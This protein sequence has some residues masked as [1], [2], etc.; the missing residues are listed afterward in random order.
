LSDNVSVNEAKTRC[1]ESSRTF[2]HRF[3]WS[4]LD[5]GGGSYAPD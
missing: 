3:P 1:L 2:A 5:R 4:P